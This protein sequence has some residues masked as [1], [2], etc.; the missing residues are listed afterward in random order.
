MAAE[1]RQVAY[2]VLK[3]RLP[4]DWTL[5]HFASKSARFNFLPVTVRGECVGAIIY[6]GH[7]VH[8]AIQPE[9]RG[10]WFGKRVSR[11]LSDRLHQY[12]KLTTKVVTGYRM[13]HAFAH[14]LGFVICGK[15]DTLTFYEKG[16]T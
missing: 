10:R 15:S 12:G 5:D 4:P 11:W 2:S 1:C 13:G 7:E 8:A 3:D 14:R 6:S 9:A 16:L